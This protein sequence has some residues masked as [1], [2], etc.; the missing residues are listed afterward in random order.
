MK[1]VINLLVAIFGTWAFG[2]DICYLINNSSMF[3]II[4]TIILGLVTILNYTVFFF[5]NGVGVVSE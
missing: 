1:A 3:L 4:I 2:F 5:E